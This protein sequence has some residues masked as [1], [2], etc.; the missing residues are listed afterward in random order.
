MFKEKV[1]ANIELELL[2]EIRIIKLLVR[3]DC[4]KMKVNVSVISHKELITH[5]TPS[6]TQEDCINLISNNLRWNTISKLRLW[7]AFH[8]KLGTRI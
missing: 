4:L 7:Q 2:L 6:L 3:S 1:K 8:A 5:Y